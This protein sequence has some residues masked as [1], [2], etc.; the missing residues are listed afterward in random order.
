MVLITGGLG[1]LGARIAQSLLIEGVKVRIATSRSNPSIPDELK[2][3]EIVQIDL[4]NSLTT[5][6]ACSGIKSIIHL[7]SLN[8]LE[9]EKDENAA[10]VINSVG[11][12]NVLKSAKKNGVKKILYFSTA[13]VYG[14]DLSGIIDENSSTHPSNY[15]SSTHK[16]A[17]EFVLNSNIQ[18]KLNACVFR[19]TNV[20]GSPLDKDTNCWMLIANDLCRKIALNQTPVLYANKFIKRDF[21]SMKDVIGATCYFLNSEDN[22]FGGEVINISSGNSITLEQICSI[23][24]DRAS[25]VLDRSTS[26][27]FKD[28]SKKQDINEFCIS[29]HKALAVG[30]SFS[31]SLLEEVDSMLLNYNK[32]FN[33]EKLPKH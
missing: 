23:F 8:S 29:N 26:I 20:I 22:K 3:C 14:P 15:Y 25:V 18:D 5:D 31:N 24:F 19:L 2:S 30:L 10:E 17:E 33:N 16:S 4:T 1:Y 11:T 12:L 13:H 6:K 7:A 27:V 32:W 21:I 28:S 9:C